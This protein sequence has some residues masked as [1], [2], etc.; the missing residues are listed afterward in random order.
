MSASAD[1][2]LLAELPSSVWT[3]V[4]RHQQACRNG[5]SMGSSAYRA[6]AVCMSRAQLPRG[7]LELYEH[8]MMA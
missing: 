1:W 7:V 8:I 3:P 5:S 4:S 2:W 6:A